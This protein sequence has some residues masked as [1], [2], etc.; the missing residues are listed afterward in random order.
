[1]ETV[2]AIILGIVQGLTEFLPVSSSGHLELAEFL[3]G[4]ENLGSDHV[5]Q[6]VVLHFATAC[7]TIVVFRRDIVDL[8]A[9]ITRSDDT[10]SRRY[11]MHI[12]LSMIPAALVGI[13]ADDWLDQLFDG[14]IWLVSIC[15]LVTGVALLIADRDWNNTAQ[16]SVKTSLAMG[17]AQMLALFPG[18]SRSGSTIATALIM[19]VDR[20]RA[21]RF[22]F[23]MVL[24]LIFG[25]IAKDI[26]SGDWSPAELSLDLGLSAIA[27]FVVGI[28]ACRLMIRWVENSK[29]RYFAYYCFAVGIITLGYLMTAS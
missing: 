6:A 4:I 24:P 15:L 17:V 26:L 18:V 29:L 14:K 23:L 11:I 22:S 5:T 27:A 3:L 19:G 12:I 8:L 2:K 7:S 25:K 20:R 16:V 9:G 1:V 10:D 28:L 21:A 13:L